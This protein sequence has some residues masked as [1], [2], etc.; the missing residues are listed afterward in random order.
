MDTPAPRAGPVNDPEETPERPPPS[1]RRANR[2]AAMQ[3]LYMAEL[4]APADEHTGLQRSLREFFEHRDHPRDYYAFGEALAHEAFRHRDEADAIVKD[5]ARNWRFE[6]IARVDLA[7]L[8]L[9]IYELKHRRDIPPIVSI[10]EAIDLAKTFSTPDSKRFVN[11]ILDRLKSTLDR[12]LRTP[13][14]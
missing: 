3:F 9:A 12:P 5:H 2:E 4:N 13:A 7:I 6:R 14:N 11:G 10:N 8:R 1:Q